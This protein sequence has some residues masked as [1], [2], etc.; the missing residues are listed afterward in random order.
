MEQVWG[1]GVE[2]RRSCLV[3]GQTQHSV[4]RW[5]DGGAVNVRRIRVHTLIFRQMSQKDAAVIMKFAFSVRLLGVPKIRIC[6]PCTCNRGGSNESEDSQISETVKYNRESRGSRNQEWLCWRR[7]A[8]IHKT[9]PDQTR[10]DQTRPDQSRPDQT[11]P[12]QSRRDQTRPDQ[13]RPDQ[14]RPDQVLYQVL[15]KFIDL[16]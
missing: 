6:S 1:R 15:L 10:P 9:R 13:T 16:V 4:P 5:V 8:A 3:P 7:P 14:T 12:D 11:R 2:I